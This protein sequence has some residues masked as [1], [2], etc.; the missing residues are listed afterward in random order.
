MDNIS[1]EPLSASS[2]DFKVRKRDKGC[3]SPGPVSGALNVAVALGWCVENREICALCRNSQNKLLS[4]LGPLCLLQQP[5]TPALAH[6]V[7]LLPVFSTPS[8][9]GETPSLALAGH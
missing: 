4:V 2:P 5:L 7:L 8:T 1:R 3:G 9:L 6:S